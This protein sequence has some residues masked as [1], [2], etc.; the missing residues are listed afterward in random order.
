MENMGKNGID[1]G[2]IKSAVFEYWIKIKNG[3]GIDRISRRRRNGNSLDSVDCKG[4]IKNVKAA[5]GKKVISLRF[6]HGSELDARL[7]R[8]R[9]MVCVIEMA[10]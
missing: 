7:Y 8:S 4:I 6:A 1:H 3:I 10:V 9:S 5:N 2:I